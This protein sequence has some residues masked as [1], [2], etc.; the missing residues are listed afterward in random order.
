MNFAYIN[1]R[2]TFFIWDTW[3]TGWMRVFSVSLSLYETLHTLASISKGPKYL[4]PSFY[5]AWYATETWTYGWS[6]KYTHSPPGSYALPIS[7]QPEISCG[8]AHA[9]GVLGSVAAWKLVLL[10]IHQVLCCLWCS[11]VKPKVSRWT[12]IQHFKRGTSQCR[13]ERCVVPIYCQR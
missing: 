9:P 8:V 1:G 5:E 13:M 11:M 2:I 6:H 3:M 7:C 10:T 4:N 12:P